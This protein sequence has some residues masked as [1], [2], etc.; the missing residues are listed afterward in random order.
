MLETFCF[1]HSICVGNVLFPSQHQC[2]KRFVSNTTSMLETCCFQ[3]SICVGNVL[4]PTQHQCWKRFV[5]NTASMLETFCFQHSICVGNVLFQ[6]QHKCWKRF[7]YN[8]A[9]MLETF[10]FISSTNIKGSVA[11]IHYFKTVWWCN[12]SDFE[13][14]PRA[15]RDEM[16][17]IWLAPG[18]EVRYWR[19]FMRE[20]HVALNLFTESDENMQPYRQPGTQTGNQTRKAGNQT[21]KQAT[22]HACRQPD[23]IC[24]IFST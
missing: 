3:H 4:F 24:T 21:R 6:T 14:S 18:V 16:D 8:T 2:W 10:A 7:V 22:R 1:Q 9:S 15:V 23:I 5:S 17:E 13:T 20:Q 11:C 12:W 19:A